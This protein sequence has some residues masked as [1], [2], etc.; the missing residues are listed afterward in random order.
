MSNTHISLQRWERDEWPEYITVSHEGMRE[1]E[2]RYVPERTCRVVATGR[3]F[4]QTQTLVTKSCS[5]CGYAFGDEEVRTSL[6]GLD[7]M[8][9]INTV[10][11]PHFC[12]NCG[13]KVEGKES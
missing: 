2:R 4:S 12:P 7:E 1:P 13:A 3:K 10:R 9:T 8:M 11:I 6:P 5:A